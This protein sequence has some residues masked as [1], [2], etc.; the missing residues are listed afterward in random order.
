[1]IRRGWLFS[2]AISPSFML[3]KALARHCYDFVVNEGCNH[4]EL[5]GNQGC[6]RFDCVFCVTIL[7]K[8]GHIQN[9]SLYSLHCLLLM[10]VMLAILGV[11]QINSTH[12]THCTDKINQD[13]PSL[14]LTLRRAKELIKDLGQ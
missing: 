4:M 8:N 11:D 14:G 13:L 2:A 1:M 10:P 9:I 12:S 7:I 6:N 5:S 3:F